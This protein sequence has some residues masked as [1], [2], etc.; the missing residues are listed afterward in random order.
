MLLGNYMIVNLFLAILLKFIAK[1]EEPKDGEDGEDADKPAEDGE[2]KAEG[3]E[4]KS[5]TI[6]GE[7]FQEQPIEQ[8]APLNSSNSNIEEE[9]EQIKVQL[10][11]LSNLNLAQ[12]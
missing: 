6:A 10:R 7:E 9:F 5:E 12:M 8:E 11:H 3:N 1:A 4:V 2:S